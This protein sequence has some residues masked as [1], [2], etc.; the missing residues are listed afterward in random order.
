MAAK[1]QGRSEGR[2]KAMKTGRRKVWSGRK[3]S[4][5]EYQRISGATESWPFTL[6]SVN[7]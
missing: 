6:A 5:A 3:F 7:V 2:C 1:P 4:V